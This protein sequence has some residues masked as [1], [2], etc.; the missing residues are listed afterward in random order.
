MKVIKGVEAGQLLVL[1]RSCLFSRMAAEI[2]ILN[3]TKEK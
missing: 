2:E 3:F 1:A